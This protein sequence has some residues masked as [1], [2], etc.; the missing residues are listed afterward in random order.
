LSFACAMGCEP[1]KTALQFMFRWSKLKGRHLS[2]WVQPQKSFHSRG[3]ATQGEFAAALTVPLDTPRSAI[4]PHVESVVR[5]LFALFGGMEFENRIIAGIVEE[6]LR[7]R[8]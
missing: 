3:P 5:K 1:S 6:S 4:A 2:A 7:I 8:F